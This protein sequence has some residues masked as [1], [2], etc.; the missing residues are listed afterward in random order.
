MEKEKRKL[1]RL[2]AITAVLLVLT[3]VGAVGVSYARY[4]Y[5]QTETLTYIA[6]QPAQVYLGKMTVSANNKPLFDPTA[7]GA[8]ETVDGI[9]KMEFTVANGTTTKRYTANDIVVSVR[10]TGG[11]GMGS[12][13]AAPIT[14]HIPQEEGEELTVVGQAE[15]IMPDSPLFNVYGEGWV[16]RFLTPEGEE[17]QLPLEGGK[18]NYVNLY[19]TADPATLADPSLL[20]LT[21][22]GRAL[23]DNH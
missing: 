11:L 23:T 12:A 10:V 13:A 20:R 18:L 22:S 8:W 16:Y 19:I 1:T 15:R 14:L 21:V 3:A 7:V 2:I 9:S 6:G 5:D 4:R 17:L